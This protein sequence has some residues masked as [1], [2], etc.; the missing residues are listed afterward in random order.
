[1]LTTFGSCLAVG[2][3]IDKK[4]KKQIQQKEQKVFLN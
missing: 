2:V 4:P 1:M 3:L